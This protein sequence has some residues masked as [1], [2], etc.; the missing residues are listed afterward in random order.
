MHSL[1]NLGLGSQSRG[2][3]RQLKLFS[4]PVAIGD[5]QSLRLLEEPQQMP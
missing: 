1:A 5:V 3:N 4:K 2:P